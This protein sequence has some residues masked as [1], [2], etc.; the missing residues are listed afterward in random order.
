MRNHRK[1]VAALL[2]SLLAVGITNANAEGISN[3]N[4]FKVQGAKLGAKQLTASQIKFAQKKAKAFPNFLG[5]SCWVN[6]GAQVSTAQRKTASK[7]AKELCKALTAANSDL[8]IDF[9]S[10]YRPD[11][12]GAKQYDLY[13]SIFDPRTIRFGG[14]YTGGEL[15]DSPSPV[16]FKQK[17]TV[18]GNVNNLENYEL[19]FLGWT[20]NYD[21]KGK[22]FVEGDKIT[23]KEPVTLYPK[24]D[25]YEVSVTVTNIGQVGLGHVGFNYLSPYSQQFQMELLGIVSG[26]TFE[27][28]G[29]DGSEQVWFT[30]PGSP[31]SNS[32]SVSG[33]IAMDFVG[34]ATCGWALDYQDCTI[35]H[36]TVTGDGTVTYDLQ[37]N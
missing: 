8:E 28:G 18:P 3:A 35:W 22:V 16:G 20:K 19:A 6:V 26:E 2:L 13:F 37:P 27:V 11:E 24:W 14:Y 12:Y 25:G 15:P 9:V 5:V 17:I 21:G 23:M 29:S 30:A 7:V 36:L 4:Y 1:I 10:T 33:D 34:S 31:P 32:L